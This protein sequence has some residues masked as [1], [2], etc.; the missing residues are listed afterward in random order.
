MYRRPAS[1]GGRAR[2]GDDRAGLAE[3]RIGMAERTRW[4]IVPRDRLEA[5]HDTAGTDVAEAQQ[6]PVSE[7]EGRAGH[8]SC[9]VAAMVS[10]DPL[11]EWLEGR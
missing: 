7:I 3:V 6:E 4:E 9:I 1:G 8:G 11:G 10:L 5:E 2:Q